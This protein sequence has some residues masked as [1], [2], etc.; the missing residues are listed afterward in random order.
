MG[1]SDRRHHPD[2]Q[3][4]RQGYR[5]LS[6]QQASR[7]GLRFWEDPALGA[8]TGAVTQTLE[9]HTSSVN[10][11]AFSPDGKLVASALGDKTIRL[12]DV[13]THAITQTLEGHTRSVNA[14]AYSPDG[15]LVASASDDKTVRLWDVVTDGITRTLEHLSGRVIATTI[16]RDGKLVVSASDDATVRL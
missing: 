11:I 14:I 6:R 1:R 10:A 2:T 7:V 8:T 12:W 3:N 13:A 15:K 4:L 5:L 9:S 16:S